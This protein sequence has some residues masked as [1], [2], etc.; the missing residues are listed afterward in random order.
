[1]LL[2]LYLMEAEEP[3]HAVYVGTSSRPYVRVSE[4]NTRLNGTRGL[5]RQTS[6]H[7]GHWRLRVIWGPFKGTHA[8]RWLSVLRA[9]LS[10]KH[11]LCLRTLIYL[12]TLRMHEKQV[13]VFISCDQAQDFVDRVQRLQAQPRL[14]E[15]HTEFLYRRRSSRI[16]CL[17][18]E[19]LVWSE[20]P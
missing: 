1:M 8:N 4:H 11:H 17:I 12:L 7:A 19:M 3:T 13:P 15:Q 14:M 5:V 2:W 18:E 9:A 16:L 10:S 6:K 20:R